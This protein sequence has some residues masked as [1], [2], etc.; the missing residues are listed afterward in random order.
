[1]ER[2]IWAKISF[3][4]EW[5]N[6]NTSKLDELLPSW[7]RKRENLKDSSGEYGEFLTQL[8]RK[9]AI[10]T[11]IIEK[12]YDLKEGIT[13]TFVKEG[14]VEV[15][16][17]HGDTN[18]PKHKLISY[19][20]DN[21]NAIDL[22]FEVV[23]TERP[24]TKGFIKELHQLTTFAQETTKVIDQFGKT[25]EVPLLKGVFKNL[26]NNPKREDGTKF[27]YCP[28]EQVDSEIENLLE[29]YEELAKQK[30]KPILIATWFH[31]SFTQIHPFQDG[32]GRIARLLASLILI[33]SGLFPL[34]VSRNERKEYLSSL[35][36]ADSNHPQ[37][38]VSFFCQLQKTNI[39]MALN[40]TISSTTLKAATEIFSKRVKDWRQNSQEKQ[41]QKISQNRTAIFNFSKEVLHELAQ[42]LKKQAEEK[43]YVEEADFKSDKNFYYLHQILA[44]SIKHRYFFKRSLPRAWFRFAVELSEER[45][46]QLIITLH[47]FSY[48]DFTLAFGAFLEFIEPETQKHSA[49]TSVRKGKGE[50]LVTA[51]PLEV[52]PYT[53]SLETELSESSKQNISSFLKDVVALALSQIASEFS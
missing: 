26:P 12:L 8:K 32:N 16:L 34:T 37:A 38:L 21:F 22:V 15:Y 5:K 27:L 11:G 48:E 30:V 35:E 13:E 47:H 20:T 42:E 41:Q 3:T 18:I 25:T 40:L 10:E 28:P 2:K 6:C 33:K 36:K 9:H 14:F 53:I 24:L 23:K 51:L 49:R 17:N 39:E 50:N 7:D 4:E 31:H 52:K 45:K 44:Y 1:M 43:I 46:Y 19:L 29:I